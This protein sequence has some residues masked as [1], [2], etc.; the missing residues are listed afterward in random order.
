MDALLKG[1]ARSFYITLR[2]LPQSIRTIFSLA[3]LLARSSDTIA[4]A[5]SVSIPERLALLRKLPSNWPDARLHN[6]WKL[7][8]SEKEL[9]DRLP[10]LL[11]SLEASPE[12]DEILRVWQTILEGQIFDLERFGGGAPPPLTPEELNNY[13]Y[14]VAGCVGEFWTRICN[15]RVR[16]YSREGIHALCVHGRAFGQGLQLVNILRDRHADAK[17]GRIYIPQERFEVEMQ[18]ART[19]LAMGKKYVLAIR[20]YRLRVAC[21]LPLEIGQRTLNRVAAF[22]NV[23]GMKISRS[24]LLRAFFGV[25]MRSVILKKDDERCLLRI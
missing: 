1:T 8:N 17:S 11:A 5:S 14:L 20:P 12:R 19:C 7:S 23:P 13:T 10:M 25:V 9:L 21:A 2:L 18:N 3:Y 22:P 24:A 15:K 6:S 4:D 16:H